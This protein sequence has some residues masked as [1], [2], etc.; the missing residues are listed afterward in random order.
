MSDE[1]T[2]LEDLLASW[3]RS[4][5]ATNLS[6]ATIKTYLLATHQLI[7]HS[8][9]HG[10][11]IGVSSVTADD[12]RS[13]LAHVLGTR[14]S[15]TARQRYASLKQLFRWLE[16]EGEIEVSPMAK[17][18][19]PRVQEQPVPVL[20]DDEITALL[21]AL[22]N[23]A[24]DQNFDDTRDLAILRMFIDTGMRLGEL[25][26]L[27]VVDI[28]LDLAV[29]VV[30]GKGRLVRSVP[31]GDRT[32]AAVDRYVRR[33]TSHY[34]ADVGLALARAQR[35]GSETRALLR[36]SPAAPSWLGLAVSTP[37]SSAIPWRIVG[38]PPV[39]RRVTCNAWLGGSLRRCWP[40]TAR[41]P[42]TREPVRLIAVSASATNSS[43]CRSPGTLTASRPSSCASCK[44]T[45]RVSAL[46]GHDA[47]QRGSHES[48]N[49]DQSAS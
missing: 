44:A 7:E 20:S 12:V 28:D 25:A 46:M 19:P 48:V 5:R 10:R 17:V 21:S 18:R 13:Y 36:W 11:P 15:A 3:I 14:A 42:R 24:R 4:M 1:S 37:T 40:G 26:G 22:P 6:E 23:R 31:F 34:A 45:S 29:A 2:P 8:R 9:S 27:R 30:L 43:L 49:R 38:L 35:A 47:P 16:E 32:S 33:R 39:A 41:L